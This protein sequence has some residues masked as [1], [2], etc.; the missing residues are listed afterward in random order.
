[1]SKWVEAI[2]TKTN[3]SKVVVKFLRKN[4]FARYGMPSLI[5]SDQW[6]RFDDRPF[7]PL[8][9]WYSIL[10]RL[11]TLYHPQINGQV[12]VSNRKIKQI[13]E[14]T[15]SKNRKNWTNKLINALWATAR[16]SRL[17]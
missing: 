6:T 12:E 8:L 9:R 16:S 5:I 4:I 15:I 3:E 1:M 10:H 7:D 2:P 13:I 17:L 14:K 11:V